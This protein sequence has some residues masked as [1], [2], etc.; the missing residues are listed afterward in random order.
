MLGLIPENAIAI[1]DREFASWRFLERL[2]ERKC[3]FV[4]RIKST[5]RMKFNHERYRVVQFF[6]ESQREF[7]IATN[8][9]HLSE[10]EVSELY[11]HR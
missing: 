2:S 1:M 10:E 9:T 6:D 3:L 11:R 7:R 4:V 8:L 5:M